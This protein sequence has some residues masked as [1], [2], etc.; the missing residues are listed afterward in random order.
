[1]IT[2]GRLQRKWHWEE[3]MIEFSFHCGTAEP[4]QTHTV[5][6]QSFLPVCGYFQ[7]LR[8]P[9]RA[10]RSALFLVFLFTCL[11]I[12]LFNFCDWRILS[13]NDLISS[14]FITPGPF[15]FS[16]SLSSAPTSLSTQLAASAFYLFVSHVLFSF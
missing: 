10:H 6:C 16:P 13:I 1:M 5:T 15:P 12:S 4:F 2:E 9:L 14:L 3:K 7:S 8:L 11:V